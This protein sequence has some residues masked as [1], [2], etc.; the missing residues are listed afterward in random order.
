MRMVH[1]KTQV[2][3]PHCGH[4]RER[5]N[6][7]AALFEKNTHFIRFGSRRLKRLGNMA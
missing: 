2:F 4:A 1:C 6:K 5:K 7:E 3:P